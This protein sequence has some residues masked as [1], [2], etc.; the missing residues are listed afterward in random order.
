MYLTLYVQFRAPDDGKKTRLKHVERPTEINKF[1]KR[2]SLLV[3]LRKYI[4]TPFALSEN[5]KFNFLIYYLYYYIFVYI[6]IYLFWYFYLTY[7]ICCRYC[8]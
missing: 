7:I 5:L 1:E 3:V 6:I 4:I 8:I 2:C